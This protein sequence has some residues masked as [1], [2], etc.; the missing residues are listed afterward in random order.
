MAGHRLAQPA[1]LPGRP[2]R[3]GRGTSRRLALPDPAWAFGVRSVETITTDLRWERLREPLTVVG[4]LA[5][6]AASLMDT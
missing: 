5:T 4:G 2:G 3:G 1:W 6:V